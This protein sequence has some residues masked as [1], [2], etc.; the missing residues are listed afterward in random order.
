MSASDF[1]VAELEAGYGGD[2]PSGSAPQRPSV[3]SN[4]LSNI[5]ST[6]F[7]DAEIR[8]GLRTLDQRGIQNSP[9]TRRRLRLDAQKE[10][11]ECNGDVIKDFG[12]VAEVGHP[13]DPP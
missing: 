11:I 13:C 9:D 8:D 4:K 6:S 2:G 7:A 10:V 1:E 5:L 3:L 12:L